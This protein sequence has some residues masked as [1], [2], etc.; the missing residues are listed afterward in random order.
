MSQPAQA[1]QHSADGSA[2]AQYDLMATSLTSAFTGQWPRAVWRWPGP[3]PQPQ[4]NLAAACR[5]WPR[6]SGPVGRNGRLSRSP[7]PV[8]LNQ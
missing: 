4:E 6:S 3:G 7:R 2:Y 1:V 8:R 5:R